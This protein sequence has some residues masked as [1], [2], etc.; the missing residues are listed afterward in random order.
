MIV[1][2]FLPRS[3]PFD[4]VTSIISNV[5]N[6]KRFELIANE[7]L[8]G[9]III[10]I[11]FEGLDSIVQKN[12]HLVQNIMRNARAEDILIE[13]YKQ[14]MKMRRKVAKQ[15]VGRGFYTMDELDR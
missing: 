2:R 6:V 15:M 10:G 1:A 14:F 7:G 3:R 13:S 12:A 8:G 11:G 5:K 9:K 4:T